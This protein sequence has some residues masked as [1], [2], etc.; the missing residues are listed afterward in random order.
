MGVDIVRRNMVRDSKYAPY[1]MRCSG[2]VRMV[3]VTLTLARC[4]CGAEHDI[5]TA[6]ITI[7]YDPI[8]KCTV[9]GSLGQGVCLYPDEMSD[10]QKDLLFELLEGEP[11]LVDELTVYNKDEIFRALFVETNTW[12]EEHVSDYGEVR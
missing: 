11:P 3:R 7:N 9:V 10:K 1:C 2:V 12:W 4:A 6:P 8:R 5:S